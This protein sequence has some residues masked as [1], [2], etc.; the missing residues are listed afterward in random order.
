[1]T[2]KVYLVGA[3]PGDPD[4]IT[5]KGRELL[6]LADVI[7]YDNLASRELLDHA[8][9][10]AERI[11]VGKKKSD[12]SLPQEEICRLLIAYARTHSIVVRLKG[13]DPYVF[14]RGGEE[15]EALAAEGIPFEVVPGVTAAL[16][17][18]AYTGV[19][20]THR[21][22]TSSVSFVTG[23]NPD[24]IDWS[25]VGHSE[26]LV[27]YM[28]L[29]TIGAIAER[30]IA[31]GRSPATPAVVVQRA[32]TPRQHTIFTSLAEI[33]SVVDAANLKPPATIV[34]G[35][36]ASLR[37]KLDWFEKQPLFGV[38]VLVT[39]AEGQ[40]DE[41]NRRLRQLG[42]N[43][44][45]VPVI[46][47]Q[48]PEDE[49]PLRSALSNLSVYDWLLFTSANAVSRFFAALLSS[50]RDARAIRGRVCAI[51]DKTAAALASAGVRPDRIAPQAIAEGVVEAFAGEDLAGARILLPRAAAGRDVIPVEFRKRGARVDVVPVYRTVVPSESR[52]RLAAID[53]VDWITF[54]S[55]STVKNFLALGGRRLLEA[56]AKTASIGPAT[57]ETMAAHE[58][59]VTVEA[60]THT[61]DGVI[62]AMLTP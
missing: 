29:T 16:G 18:A 61:M 44:L 53:R 59:R 14:G 17:L 36:V 45:D 3:G 2:G 41:G 62:A 38:N 32:T 20:L 46:A 23:H 39:R 27:I 25:R 51:G 30:L 6:G 21:E 50:G 37:G 10:D 48:P 57:S 28:G 22:H 31:A 15:V 52:E 56:G 9:P 19:P 4:L 33:K 34:I 7:L 42:A 35:E 11:Y 43:V 49:A 60:R 55:S 8:R 47:I 12:H 26:T 40:G 1:M 5:V 54:T 13:G 24:Q 58:V